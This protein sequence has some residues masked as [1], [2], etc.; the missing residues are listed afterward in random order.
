M[1]DQQKKAIQATLLKLHIDHF[2][3]C[4]KMLGERVHSYDI[5]DKE[6]HGDKHAY[7]K[8]I[9]QREKG[10]LMTFNGVECSRDVVMGQ[11]EDELKLLNN[12]K[13]V[14]VVGGAV[15]ALKLL[16]SS[17]THD[18]EEEEEEESINND[19][20]EA[21]EKYIG[22]ISTSPKTW[23]FKMQHKSQKLQ[24]GK[25]ASPEEAA[26]E[27]DLL[28]INLSSSKSTVRLN[29]PERREHYFNQKSKYLDNIIKKI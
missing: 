11:L 14:Y 28:K 20:I 18:E 1:T 6:L 12:I 29:F 26:M 21:G 9:L 8:T 5:I 25:F 4:V 17:H 19:T 22:V 24:T 15:D 27:Y 23:A 10:P 13:N 7:I 3:L 16:S 2:D